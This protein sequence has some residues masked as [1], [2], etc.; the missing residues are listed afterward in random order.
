[1]NCVAARKLKELHSKCLLEELMRR[2]H[3]GDLGVNGRIMLNWGLNGHDMKKTGLNSEHN[4]RVGFCDD[5]DKH[6]GVK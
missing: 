5:G 6:C 1:M 2:D 4:S 3:L